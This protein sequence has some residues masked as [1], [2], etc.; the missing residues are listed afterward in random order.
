[1]HENE[2]ALLFLLGDLAP[3]ASFV[4]EGEVEEARDEHAVRGLPLAPLRRVRLRRRREHDLEDRERTGR[5]VVRSNHS[6]RE[7]N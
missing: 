1:M 3:S 6:C 5:G 2:N 4:T 7:L